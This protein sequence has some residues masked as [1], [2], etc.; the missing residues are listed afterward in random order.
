M[1]PMLCQFVNF[2]LFL[3]EDRN[4]FLPQQDSG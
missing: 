4:F 2:P 1:Q 3:E